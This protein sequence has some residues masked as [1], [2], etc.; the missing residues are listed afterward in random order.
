AGKAKH[1]YFASRLSRNS[2]SASG[3]AIKRITARIG[4]PS[5]VSREASGRTALRDSFCDVS[6]VIT[7]LPIFSLTPDFG[8]EQSVRPEIQRNDDQQ[9]DG[10]FGHRAGHQKFEGRLQLADDEGR[11]ERPE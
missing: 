6:A 11:Q 9:Q 3:I 7:P 10:R 5:R 2:E 1:K 4:R 8:R